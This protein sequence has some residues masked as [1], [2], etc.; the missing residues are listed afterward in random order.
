MQYTITFKK[1]SEISDKKTKICTVYP[2]GTADF[3]RRSINLTKN[4][5]ITLNNIIYGSINNINNNVNN[6]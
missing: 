6:T 2:D 4:K 3:K 5:K 1:K